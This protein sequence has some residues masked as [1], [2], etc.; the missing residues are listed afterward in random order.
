MA[1]LPSPPATPM[2]SSHG[3]RAPHPQAHETTGAAGQP[4]HISSR[5][6]DRHSSRSAQGEA[7]PLSEV[8]S[9]GN[10]GQKTG[11]WIWLASDSLGRHWPRCFL[12]VLVRPERGQKGDWALIDR[13]WHSFFEAGE[14]IGF[15]RLMIFLAVYVLG[16]GLIFATIGVQ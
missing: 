2:D 1:V 15:L 9:T 12:I 7:A 8:W 16:F 14:M 10:A 6:D 4:A 13:I 11:W 5:G 3:R